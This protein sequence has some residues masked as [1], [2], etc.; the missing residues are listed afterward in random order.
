MLAIFTSWS[1]LC[2]FI[3]YHVYLFVAGKFSKD[4][5]TKIYQMMK[6][7]PSQRDYYAKCLAPIQVDYVKSQP[8]KIKRS[9]RLMKSWVKENEVISITIFIRLVLEYLFFFSYA[10]VIVRVSIQF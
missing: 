8:E 5:L 6:D 10:Y 3:V 9:I 4:D 2:R 7:N 1:L